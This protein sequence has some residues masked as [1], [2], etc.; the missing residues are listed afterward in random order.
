MKLEFSG[1]ILERKAEI[2]N[3][4]KICPVG[5]ESVHVGL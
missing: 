1:E 3:F 4:I 5:V 2:L